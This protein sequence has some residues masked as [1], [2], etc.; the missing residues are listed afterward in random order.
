MRYK[1]Y[2]SITKTYIGAYSTLESVRL[3]RFIIVASL[4]QRSV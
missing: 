1:I 3:A 4:S 2:R